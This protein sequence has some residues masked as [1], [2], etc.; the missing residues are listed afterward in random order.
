VAGPVPL[1][2][3]RERVGLTQQ[4]LA[5]AMGVAQPDL[6]RL[7]RRADARLSTLRAYVEATGARLRLIAELGPDHVQVTLG[8]EAPSG[9]GS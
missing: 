9:L 6:S 5:S 1:R 2:E 3:L 7:E 4:Q 8:P